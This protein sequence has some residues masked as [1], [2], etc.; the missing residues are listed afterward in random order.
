MIVLI[1]MGSI[2]LL[3]LGSSDYVPRCGVEMVANGQR[4]RWMCSAEREGVIR[5]RQTEATGATNTVSLA[6]L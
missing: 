3:R 2:R 4:I 1:R 5:M 6:R